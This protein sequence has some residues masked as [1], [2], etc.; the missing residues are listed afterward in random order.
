MAGHLSSSCSARCMMGGFCRSHM[1]WMPFMALTH[2]IPT[3]CCVQI[4]A[5]N[6]AASRPTHA[7]AI[8]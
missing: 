1:P 7:L 4:A 6:A 2:G 5:T 3:T 8:A